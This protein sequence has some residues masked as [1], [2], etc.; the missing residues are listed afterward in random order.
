[1]SNYFD[2][3]WVYRDPAPLLDPADRKIVVEHARGSSLADIVLTS[4]RK[5]DYILK[6]LNLH[7][8]DFGEDAMQEAAAAWAKVEEYKIENQ[9]ARNRKHR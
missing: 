6:I 9:L 3:S 5:P 8:Q 2:E 4:H 1:M 7:P